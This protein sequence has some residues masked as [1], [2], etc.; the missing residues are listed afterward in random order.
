MKLD[1]RRER[2][3]Q[4]RGGVE[5]DD[6]GGVKGVQAE[7]CAGHRSA[8]AWTMYMEMHLCPPCPD[9]SRHVQTCPDMPRQSCLLEIS[10]SDTT[11]ITSGRR[12]ACIFSLA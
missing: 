10:S 1:V 12:A 11:R 3:E 2:A 4:E 7:A 8:I 6:V 5:A 9:M